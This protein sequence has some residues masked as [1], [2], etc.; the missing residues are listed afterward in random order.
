MH[1]VVKQGT[2]ASGPRLWNGQSCEPGSPPI[3]GTLVSRFSQ[4]TI[5]WRLSRF[6]FG[7]FGE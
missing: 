6:G 3:W 1:R 4:R 5:T 7:T 2:I